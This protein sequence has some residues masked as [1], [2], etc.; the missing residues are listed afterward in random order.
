MPVIKIASRP[1]NPVLL[2]AFSTAEPVAFAQAPD[3]PSDEARP[4]L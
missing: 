1:V 4:G 3:A 2:A